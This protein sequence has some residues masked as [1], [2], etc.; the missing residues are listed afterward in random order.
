MAFSSGDVISVLYM[1]DEASWWWGVRKD[2]KEGWFPAS[3]VRVS[4][5]Y[6][7]SKCIQHWHCLLPIQI[8]GIRCHFPLV[9]LHNLFYFHSRW[10]QPRSFS[11]ESWWDFSESGI[12]GNI[13]NPFVLGYSLQL[14]IWYI[15][16]MILLKFDKASGFGNW[17]C[18]FRE[19]I[20]S[21]W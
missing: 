11:V 8:Y 2:G 21:S 10:S 9:S 7:L 17:E 19:M 20:N 18:W 16:L 5:H 3:Y 15:P 12:V 14:I 6:S 1:E 4:N 13:F